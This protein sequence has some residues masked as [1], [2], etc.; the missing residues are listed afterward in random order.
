LS[1]SENTSDTELRVTRR[2]DELALAPAYHASTIVR[3]KPNAVMATMMPMT[4]SVVRSRWRN[5]LRSTSR[6]TNTGK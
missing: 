3:S 6:G 1:G 2:A 5:A 4:V